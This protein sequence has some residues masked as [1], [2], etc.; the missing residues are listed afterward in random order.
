MPTY[1]ISSTRKHVRITWKEFETTRFFWPAF[2]DISW[3]RLDAARISD[4]ARLV[5]RHRR[6]DFWSILLLVRVSF[7]RNCDPSRAGDAVREAYVSAFGRRK[8]RAAMKHCPDDGL[9]RVI[10]VSFR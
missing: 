3:Q 4:P 9:S 6:T 7:L 10:L 2:E 1:Q 5:A 8:V